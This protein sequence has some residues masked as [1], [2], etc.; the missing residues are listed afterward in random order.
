[1]F[2]RNGEKYQS[3]HFPEY[4]RALLETF[5]AYFYVTLAEPLL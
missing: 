4:S 3:F 5:L 2:L 1:M